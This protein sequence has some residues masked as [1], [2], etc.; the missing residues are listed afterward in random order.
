[1]NSVNVYTTFDDFRTFSR[2]YY[3]I[4]SNARPNFGLLPRDKECFPPNIG[5]ANGH[6]RGASGDSRAG[7]NSIC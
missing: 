4:A 1:M 6:A 7:V 3:S 2:V 5:V